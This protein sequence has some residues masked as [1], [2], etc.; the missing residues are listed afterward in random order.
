MS[1]AFTNLSVAATLILTSFWLP[2]EWVAAAFAA[3]KKSTIDEKKLT[4][5]KH[6]T[7][8]LQSTLQKKKAIVAV[9]SRKGGNDVKGRDWTGMAHSGLAVYD[10]RVQTWILYQIL[11]SPSGGQPSAQLWRMAPIDFFYGQ[12]G[13]EENALLLIPDKETQDRIYESVLNGK[14]WKMAFTKK[15]NLLSR[16]D[17]FDSLNCNKWILLT[18]AAAR[19][20]EYDPAKVLAIV[21]KGFNP[22]KL[23]FGFIAKQVVKRK[24]NV[25]VDELPNLG[26]VET[27]TPQSLYDSGL[28][29]E[30][31][32]ANLQST[33]SAR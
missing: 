29:Q 2:G 27:V 28:F 14:A 4:V 12:T 30:K 33:G 16:Y 20:D 24:S 23:K 10:P 17:S 9:V 32:F 18:I 3:E 22:A 11:N 6:L 8:W 7:D 1:C 5:A 19:S 13:Y 31:I 25:L 21:H 15:Y 26:K